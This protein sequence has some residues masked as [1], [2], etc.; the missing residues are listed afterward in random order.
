MLL[1]PFIYES[2]EASPDSCDPFRE[3]QTLESSCSLAGVVV[4]PLSCVISVAMNSANDP[5]ANK[6]QL[7]AY[8][9]IMSG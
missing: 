1:A 4:S 3:V 7:G 5:L 2:G 9:S 6:M 8:P